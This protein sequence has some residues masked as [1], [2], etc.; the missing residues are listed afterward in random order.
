MAKKRQVVTETFTEGNFM[1]P[2]EDEIRVSAATAEDLEA[3][4]V[5]RA[6]RISLLSDEE[7]AERESEYKAQ[8]EKVAKARGG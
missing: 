1:F 4:K 5:R 8:A 7:K 2:W 6:Y 3:W